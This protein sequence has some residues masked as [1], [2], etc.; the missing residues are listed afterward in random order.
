MGALINGVAVLDGKSDNAATLGMLGTADSL[1]LT[2][3]H[4]QIGFL[5]GVDRIRG[6]G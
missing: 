3:K 6:V 5:H 4:V 2:K 1:A